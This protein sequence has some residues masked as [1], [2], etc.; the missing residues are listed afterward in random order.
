M[1]SADWNVVVTL[2]PEGFRDAVR[3]LSRFGRV[4]RTPYWD[5]L[6]M[7]TEQRPRELLDAL[8]RELDEDA[9]LGNSVSRLVPVT[10]AFEFA[11]PEE[12]RD[13]VRRIALPWAA[14]LTGKTFHVRMHRRGFKGRLASN[15]EE[16]AL[17]EDLL[18]EVQRLGGSAQ[19]AF[20]QPDWI[21]DIETVGTRA[22]LSRWRREELE[23]YVL[24]RLN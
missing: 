18:Q 1:R 13:A 21:I 20:R 5:V 23:R 7:H 11:S 3:V 16:R 4:S 10:D 6:V 12:F 9:S 14:D 17:G 8:Q 15:E 2:L 24:L 19:V 22:G